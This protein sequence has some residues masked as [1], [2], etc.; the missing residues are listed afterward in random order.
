MLASRKLL[1]AFSFALIL[2]A[3]AGL[4]F[5]VFGASGATGTDQDFLKQGVGNIQNWPQQAQALCKKSQDDAI[6]ACSS[7]SSRMGLGG[8]WVMRSIYGK[9]FVPTDTPIGVEVSDIVVGKFN[10]P[11]QN[12]LVDSTGHMALQE[13]IYSTTVAYGRSSQKAGARNVPGGDDDSQFV[14]SFTCSAWPCKGADPKKNC[15]DHYFND[16]NNDGK[17]DDTAGAFAGKTKKE[18]ENI[19]VNGQ[20]SAAGGYY[21]GLKLLCEGDQ[22]SAWWQI[23]KTKGCQ[24]NG[25]KTEEIPIDSS[26]AAIPV[27][28]LSWCD[29]TGCHKYVAKPGFTAGMSC[30]TIKDK[31]VCAGVDIANPNYKK[32][33]TTIMRTCCGCTCDNRFLTPS[34]NPATYVPLNYDPFAQ[35]FV[36]NPVEKV[37]EKDIDKNLK[38]VVDS[39]AKLPSIVTPLFG[40]EKI[41]L[42]VDAGN[43]KKVQYGLSI[44]NGDI[45]GSQKGA[46]NDAT[47]KV[48]TDQKTYNKIKDSKDP[49]TELIRA[50]NDKS[51]KYSATSFGGQTKLALVDFAAKVFS[52]LNVPPA[53]VKPGE[54]KT[55]VVDGQSGTVKG[56][57]AGVSVFSSPNTNAQQVVNNYGN[58]YGYT[59]ATT[60]NLIKS[61]PADYSKNAG[62]YNYPTENYANY[63]AT[64][65]SKPPAPTPGTSL[66][67]A[68]ANAYTAQSNAVK[69]GFGGQSGASYARTGFAPRAM[70][71]ESSAG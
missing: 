13:S 32:P 14:C 50:L 24:S 37:L 20:P 10:C 52:G 7:Y 4:A 64:T 58:A 28:E 31:L 59:S 1:L 42:D 6:A 51:I 29:S 44:S 45:K 25:C 17:N 69:G 40:N 15:D 21:Y 18:F 68:A 35:A 43:G 27:G 11:P 49:S 38:A 47:L 3:P 33:V 57:P 62:I 39:K 63:W 61:S 67:E 53:L 12:L 2:I 46:L 70:P 60:Q 36:P 23:W 8:W 26:S 9:S 65:P 34:F 71:G 5:N 55:I 48:S 16:K 66:Y 41:N 56:N 54:T 19:V 30:Q 22:K